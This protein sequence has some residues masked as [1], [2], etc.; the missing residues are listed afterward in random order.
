MT[1]PGEHIKRPMNAYMVWSRK[2]RR[3]IAEECP[4]MLNSEISKRLG[5]EW[6]SLTPDQK[7]PY[8]EEAKKLREKHKKD[9]PEYK[10]QPKRK[11]KALPKLK[12]PGLGPYPYPE[13]ALGIP[14][15]PHSICTPLPGQVLAAPPPSVYTANCTGNCSMVEPPPPYHFQP[16][17]PGLPSPPE[18]KTSCSPFARDLTYPPSPIAYATHL[19][20][21]SHLSA[22]QMAGHFVHHRGI[23]TDSGPAVIHAPTPIDSRSGMPR[24]PAE[25][26]VIRPDIRY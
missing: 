22:A 1:K 15:P 18:L 20:T 14:P 23:M 16:H 9:H 26:V 10:Y 13:M 4:R 2:E 6:N 24:L 19:P 21:R 7:D 3:R 17:Y 8:V 12:T 11:P 25:R 5:M